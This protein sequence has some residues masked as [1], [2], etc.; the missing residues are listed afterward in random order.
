MQFHKHRTLY[1]L[2]CKEVA[3]HRMQSPR[4]YYEWFIQRHKHNEMAF[5]IAN[6]EYWWHCTHRPY[7]NIYPCVLHGFANMKLKM[8]FAR[9]NLPHNPMCINLPIRHEIQIEGATGIMDRVCSL[10]VKETK[11]QFQMFMLSRNNSAI[12]MSVFGV[13]YNHDADDLEQYIDHVVANC[14]YSITMN[15]TTIKQ[16]IRVVFAL[17]IV[18]NDPTSDL[19]SRIVKPKDQKQFN[20]TSDPVQQK[21]ILKRANSAGIRGWAIG[22]QTENSPH[23]RQGCF[24]IYHCG[25]QRAQPTI[26]WRRGCTVNRKKITDVPTGYYDKETTH[27]ES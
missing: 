12:S 14:T 3:R 1:D 11:D 21:K 18:I 20:Q 24:A 25:P 13:P 2:A 7:Y 10:L 8:P 4:T 5:G 16:C 19:L 22:A 23:Y 15:A 6:F 17:G 9:L 27:A 26:K